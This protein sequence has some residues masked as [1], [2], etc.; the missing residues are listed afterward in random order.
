[1]KR[2]W[3]GFRFL[4]ALSGLILGIGCSTVEDHSLTYRL[5]DRN[6][7]GLYTPSQTP[8]AK[9]SLVPSKKDLLVEYDEINDSSDHVKRRAYLAQA[10]RTRIEHQ[11]KPKF[12]RRS[13]VE[14]LDKVA[15]QGD[16][17]DPNSPS[18]RIE[19][20]DF[21]IWEGNSETRYSFPVY[22]HPATSAVQISLTPLAITGDVV[23]VGLVASLVAGIAYVSGGG[24]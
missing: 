15:L 11:R 9:I 5:W 1:M 7:L 6:V 2:V 18:V 14:K 24:F 20:T 19:Q 3:H 16:P 10:N 8:D 23:M 4:L 17:K 12:L 21:L 13:T 22:P